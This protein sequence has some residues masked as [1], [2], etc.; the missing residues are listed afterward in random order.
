MATADTGSRCVFDARALR[1]FSMVAS[2][3]RAARFWPRD[4]A[5]GSANR[6]P[7]FLVR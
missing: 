3:G 7:L 5:S 1:E 2:G 4:Y 6:Y